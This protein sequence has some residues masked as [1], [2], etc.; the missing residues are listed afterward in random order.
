MKFDVAHTSIFI[1]LILSSACRQFVYNETEMSL[2]KKKLTEEYVF[3]YNNNIDPLKG[4]SHSVFYLL[5]KKTKELQQFFTHVGDKMRNSS[6][7]KFLRETNTCDELWNF[8]PDLCIKVIIKPLVKLLAF[9][10][11]KAA[12]F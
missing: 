7:L 8:I 10:T 1:S 11:A 3:A 4:H 2:F 6:R 5:K 12:K 9:I